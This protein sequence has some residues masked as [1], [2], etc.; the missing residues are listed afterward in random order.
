DC[1]DGS[2]E[3]PNLVVSCNPG[4]VRCVNP[5]VGQLCVS[6]SSICDGTRDCADGS[7]EDP[8]YCGEI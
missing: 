3:D 7:D 5:G 8:K 1:A 6:R 4:E 2:D